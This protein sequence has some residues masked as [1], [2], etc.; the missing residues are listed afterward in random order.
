MNLFQ[1]GSKSLILL[2]K[3]VSTKKLLYSGNFNSGKDFRQGQKMQVC[4]FSFCQWIVATKWFCFEKMWFQN[5]FKSL[6]EK[7]IIVLSNNII[8]VKHANMVK[9]SRCQLHLVSYCLYI[10]SLWQRKAFHFFSAILLELT[11]FLNIS[12]HNFKLLY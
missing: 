10:K 12:I 5:N 2:I 8:Y 9:Q 7:V 3:R 6:K 4:F 1:G 11:I